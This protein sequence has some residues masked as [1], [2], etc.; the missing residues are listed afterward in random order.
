MKVTKLVQ[1]RPESSKMLQ[2]VVPE[3]TELL[4]AE[5][6]PDIPYERTIEQARRE[7]LVILHTSR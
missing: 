7:P 1:G 3:E 5:F 6:V 4:K 2:Y